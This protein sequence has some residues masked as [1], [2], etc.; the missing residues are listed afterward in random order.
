VSIHNQPDLYHAVQ[1]VETLLQRVVDVVGNAR[2]MP[3]STSVMIPRDDV[4]DLVEQAL[5]R[6]PEEMRAAR[7]L[8]RERDD[9]LRKTE[10]EGDEI[11]EEARN[12]AERMVQRSEVVRA[13]EQTARRTIEEAEDEARRLRHEAEDFCDQRL[14]QF[15][16]ILERTLGMVR[17]GRTRFT[18]VPL[19]PTPE[20]P[21]DDVEHSFF[22]Q[23]L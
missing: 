10:R 1:D 20:E 11:L 4:L 15:E 2:L 5:E 22:D 19:L 12:R 14:A 21:S 9:F 13:A 16:G 7:W 6:L 8:L 18:A 23:D 17:E 3:L